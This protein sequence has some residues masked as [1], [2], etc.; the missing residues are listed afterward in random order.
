ML[1]SLK[2][3]NWAIDLQSGLSPSDELLGWLLS[4]DVLRSYSAS[5]ARQ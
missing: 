1:T 4:P 2:A 5:N 3:I